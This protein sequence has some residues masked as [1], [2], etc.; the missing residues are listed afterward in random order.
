MPSP[1]GDVHIPELSAAFASCP[2]QTAGTYGVAGSSATWAAANRTTT[3]FNAV[4]YR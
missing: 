3:P 1:T 2:G 4:S